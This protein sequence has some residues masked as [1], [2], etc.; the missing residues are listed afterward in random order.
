MSVSQGRIPILGGSK[1]KYTFTQATGQYVALSS[2]YIVLGATEPT[3]DTIQFT[4]QASDFPVI[5][6]AEKVDYCA[7]IHLKIYNGDG[8]SRTRYIKTSLNGV[9]GVQNSYSII[10]GYYYHSLSNIANCSVGDTVGV[11]IWVPSSTAVV[12]RA[13]ALLVLPYKVILTSKSNALF[14]NVYM[15]WAAPK[16]PTMTNDVAY[17]YPILRYGELSPSYGSLRGTMA[18]TS[19]DITAGSTTFHF[20]LFANN[21]VNGII[22]NPEA[23]VTLNQTVPIVSS[24]T[25]EVLRGN[26]AVMPA[27]IE[28]ETLN[29]RAG[30]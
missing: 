7:H 30:Y 19:G 23:Y 16:P 17:S 2:P 8:A 29:L 15:T 6:G 27:T 28:Y 18:G 22:V 26:K 9:L 24:S 14:S 10:N 20:K 1:R 11:R 13:Y 4:L 5:T 21:S 25:D 12:V 3:E